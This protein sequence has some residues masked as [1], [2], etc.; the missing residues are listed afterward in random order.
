MTL[1]FSS[2]VL[3]DWARLSI[4]DPSIFKV[5]VIV[6]PCALDSSRQKLTRFP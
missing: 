5:A 2:T 4:S 6:F 3:D 1:N